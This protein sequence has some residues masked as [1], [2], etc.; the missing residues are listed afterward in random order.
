LPLLVKVSNISSKSCEDTSA[1]SKYNP[2]ISANCV[3]TPGI[4]CSLKIKIKIKIKIKKE[5][6]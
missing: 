5:L 6:D 3:V 1:S 2:R 4:G